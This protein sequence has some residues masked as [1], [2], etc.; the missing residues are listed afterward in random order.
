V[1]D[2]IGEIVDLKSLGIFS[3]FNGIDIDQRR[4]YVKVSC[5]SYLAHTDAEDSWLGQ[6]FYDGE[7]RGLEG[8]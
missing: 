8:L 5:I 7:Y 1:I 2:S 4:E 3:S 6:T